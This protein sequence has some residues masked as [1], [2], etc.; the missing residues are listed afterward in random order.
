MLLKFLREEIGNDLAGSGGN[1][2]RA[3]LERGK[4]NG[5]KRL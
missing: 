3:G 4:V 2:E 1:K 5:E